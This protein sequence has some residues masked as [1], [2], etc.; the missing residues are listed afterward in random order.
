MKVKVVSKVGCPRCLLLKQKLDLLGVEWGDAN[1]P[2]IDIKGMKYPVTIIDGVL[3]E[4]SAAIKRL[5]EMLDEDN[6]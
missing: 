1:D 3:Y 5:K 2:E 4:Y 6:A